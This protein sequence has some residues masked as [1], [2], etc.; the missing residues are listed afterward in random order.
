MA[1]WSH[2]YD[3]P[4]DTFSPV[5]IWNYLNLRANDYSKFSYRLVEV[6][7][8]EDFYSNFLQ[9]KGKLLHS[10]HRGKWW[11]HS[12]AE[13]LTCKSSWAAFSLWHLLHKELR[14]NKWR[15]TGWKTETGKKDSFLNVF[16]GAFKQAQWG[17]HTYM[18]ASLKHWSISC[19]FFFSSLFCP[20]LGIYLFKAL[21][22]LSLKQPCPQGR[23]DALA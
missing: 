9:G 21:K 5:L 13:N 15:M 11:L 8:W 23:L 7:T 14:Q 18:R 10:L 19:G 2:V 17:F 6:H 22:G 4:A 12:K 16:K 1:F 20:A 3:G